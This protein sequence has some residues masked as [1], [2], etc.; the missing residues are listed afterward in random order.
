MSRD[1]IDYNFT[2]NGVVYNF[3]DVFVPAEN[4]NQPRLWT[5]GPNG[6][7]QLGVNDTTQRNTPVTTLLGGTNWKQVSVGYQFSTAWNFMDLGS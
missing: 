7:G 3:Y 5:W 6:Y 4:F 2:E 1:Q